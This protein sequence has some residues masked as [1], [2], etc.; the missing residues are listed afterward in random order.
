[1]SSR[2]RGTAGKKWLG[3][4]LPTNR[5]QWLGAGFGT[6]LGGLLCVGVLTLTHGLGGIAAA[7][8]AGTLIGVGFLLARV[9]L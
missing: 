1:M 8:I 7:A 4:E 6:I 2:P 9:A 3:I 5:A